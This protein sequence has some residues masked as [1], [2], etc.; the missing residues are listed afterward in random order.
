MDNDF[1]LIVSS[2]ISELKY[3]NDVLVQRCISLSQK[4]A[5]VLAERDK[6]LKEAEELKTDTE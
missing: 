3:Q 6:L 5:I 4:L 2:S 1:E